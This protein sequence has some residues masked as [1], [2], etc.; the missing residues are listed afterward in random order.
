LNLDKK[1]IKS[2]YDLSNAFVRHYKHNIGCAPYKSSLKKLKMNKGEDFRSFALRWRNQ[3]AQ[4]E[5]PMTE[6]DLIDAF[7]EIEDLNKQYKVACATA[8]DFAHLLSTGSRIEAALKS[9]SDA[10][11]GSRKKKE[12]GI[13]HV[14][15]N[16]AGPAQFTN[17]PYKAPYRANYQA[18]YRPQMYYPPPVPTPQVHIQAPQQ[19]PQVQRKNPPT[20]SYPPLPVSQAEIYK[21]LVAGGLVSPVPTNP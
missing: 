21:Q 3:A 11:E 14:V 5:P 1:E 8:T 6:K 7:M 17:S 4:V 19:K 16:A 18:Q 12:G 13:Q 20:P 15:A 10:S 9:S 2:W